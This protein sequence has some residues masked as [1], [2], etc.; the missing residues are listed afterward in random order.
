MT[1]LF[2]RSLTPMEVPSVAPD[3]SSL[4]VPPEL[5]TH[6]TGSGRHAKR[7]GFA[8]GIFWK[9]ATTV[10]LLVLFDLA[11][12]TRHQL[13]VSR[14]CALVLVVALPG[15]AI[16][17]A[18]RVRLESRCGQV[19]LI[20]G[21]GVAVLMGWAA[22]SS[23]ILPRL[24]VPLPLE[25]W[26][27]TIAVN[28]I[29]LSAVLCCPKGTDP[30]LDLFGATPPRP[31]ILVAVG[32]TLLPVAAV[33]GAERLNN[34][35]GGTLNFIVLVAFFAMLGAT[36]LK[37][38]VWS[39]GR[40]QILLFS[41]ALALI[42][43]YSYRSNYLYGFDI[44]QEFQ[45]FAYTS[46]GRWVPPDNGD[47]YSAMLSI[48]ALPTVLV[49]VSG[50]SG[51][52][53]FKGV[54]P[55][56]LAAVPPLTY[57]F[58]RRWLSALPA[59]ISAAY[60]IVLSQF[61]GELSGISRQE[62]GLFYLAL[63]VVA[64]FDPGPKGL[65]RTL[66][67]VCII[68][69]LVVSH[70]STSYVTVVVLVVTWAAYGLVR[71]VPGRRAKLR[72]N[73]K[74]INFPIVAAG[75]LFVWLWDV[76]ITATAHNLTSFLSSFV[77]NG[78]KFLPNVHSSIWSRWL[79]GNVG[80]TVSPS[81]YY[82]LALEASHFEP[83]LH[84]YPLSLTAQYPAHAVP[85]PAPTGSGPFVK[86]V[87]IADPVV[88]ELFLLTVVLG[89]V[90]MLVRSRRSLVP[91]EVTVLC[92][93]T[94]GF[95]GLVRV[96]GNIA[97]VYNQERAQVQAGIILSVSM[98]VAIQWVAR[99]LHS[100]A[101][102]GAVLGLL[103]LGVATTGVT[104]AAGNQ[105]LSNGGRAYD[106]FYIGDQDVAA[107]RWLVAEGGPDA[108]I[109]T[110]Q[111]GELRVWAGTGHAAATHT[112]L[113]PA[114]IDRGGWVLATGYNLAGRAYGT[115]AGKGATYQF[116]SA[117]LNRAKNTVYSSPGARVYR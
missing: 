95:V 6:F 63:L 49:K 54:Y 33:A 46:G 42:Y 61:A 64:L 50:V 106:Q 53:V 109:W 104:A 98:A 40:V 67:V 89:M 92:F 78:P 15:L 116:P 84:R 94:L 10:A 103:V 56:F 18:T 21:A 1:A 117:F 48:T 9:S 96:S 29:V 45:R 112:D 7:A 69:A 73:K 28:A 85:S 17:A 34:G 65:R 110:D 47:P 101:T 90:I 83:W 74:A 80:Q 62:V 51:L 57:A 35:Q 86:L 41:S 107:S 5:V 111:Y 8:A 26:P 87:A 13:L 66:A 31:S 93:A 25:T 43:L 37:A 114:T 16:V 14:I 32:A 81:A 55:L 44:Q 39:N 108:L 82:R 102:G 4:P 20:A 12:A 77:E 75:C 19:A 11:V 97:G 60:L 24:G 72:R 71:R 52:S 2:E 88:S 115:V 79:D 36:L 105:L 23:V 91:L 30:V 76:K 100:L 58:V 59:A 3:V 22:V 99:R 27:L 68:G 38:S 113:T 70:Y